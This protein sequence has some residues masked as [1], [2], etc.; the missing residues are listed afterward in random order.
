MPQNDV[1][2]SAGRAFRVLELFERERRELRLGEVT[3][4]LGLPASSAAALMK[5]LVVLGYLQYDRSKRAYLPTMR[6]A[7]LGN[8]I[9]PTLF[10]SSD[11]L[12][13]ASELHAET[14]LVVV[15]AVRSDL[16]AQY[17]HLVHR[18]GPLSLRVSPGELRPLARSAMGWLLLSLI[19]DTDV[20]ALV[21]RINY[22]ADRRTRRFGKFNYPTSTSAR[23]GLRVL[24]ERCRGRPRTDWRF[25]ALDSERPAT[26]HRRKRSHRRTGEA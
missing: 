5:S 25:G 13:R 10:G 23:S 1:I 6:M 9:E 19:E 4:I 26:G 15:L 16:Y 7:V 17:I 8:W 18:G 22:L 21:R 20:R 12:S 3:A 24:A 2:K 11:V 14:G